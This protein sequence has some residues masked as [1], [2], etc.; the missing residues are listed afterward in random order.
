M[1]KHPL[2]EDMRMYYGGTYIFRI[3][4]GEVETMLVETTERKGDDTDLKNVI[5]WGQAFNEKGEL[6]EAKWS[7][8]DM[9]NFRP[10]SGYYDLKGNGVRDR[11]VTYTVSNRSQRKG[12][13]NRAC[14]VNNQ[15]Y[16]IT[17]RELARMYPQAQAMD[18]RP[19]H[20]DIFIKGTEVHWKGYMVGKFDA[21]KFVAD[22]KF[23]KLETLICQLLQSI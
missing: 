7:G 9:V 8:A 21:K 3:V 20:R 14:I 17:G 18:S 22:D 2:T 16:N 13:D 23:K 1:N 11:Y 19:G 5:F 12:F 6:G 15:G 10:P 4:N